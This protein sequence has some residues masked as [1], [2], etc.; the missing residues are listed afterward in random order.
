MCIHHPFPFG[1]VRMSSTD[2][3]GLQMLHLGEN[4]VAISHLVYLNYFFFR[5][6]NLKFK[7]G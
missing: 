2:V 7:N 3:L 4:I 5:I 6:K 1:G